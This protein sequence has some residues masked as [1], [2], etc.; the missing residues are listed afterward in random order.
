[1][2]IQNKVI[3]ENKYFLW[4]SREMDHSIYLFE[5]FIL[6]N[7]IVVVI[8]SVKL[9]AHL[10]VTGRFILL[11]FI[12][13]TT[14]TD[15]SCWYFVGFLCLYVAVETRHQIST[16]CIGRFPVSRQNTIILFQPL[17]IGLIIL[18]SFADLTHKS[19]LFI[20]ACLCG[21]GPNRGANVKC[22]KIHI[23]YMESHFY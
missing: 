22:E 17:T 5:V 9:R 4:Y 14:F 3:L 2:S 20:G 6:L 11:S 8:Q 1:M 19:P 23:L 16:D 18:L 10:L 7:R 13:Y 15:P 12:F 21:Y